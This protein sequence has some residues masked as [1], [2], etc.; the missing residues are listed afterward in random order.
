MIG[1]WLTILFAIVIAVTAAF[2][3]YSL[4]QRRKNREAG[5]EPPRQVEPPT[6]KRTPR[7]RAEDRRRA[8]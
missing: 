8:G 1:A 7:E 3:F 2:L 6:N 4:N 5:I